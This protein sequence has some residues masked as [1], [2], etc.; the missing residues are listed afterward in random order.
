M[1]I[2]GQQLAGS[3]FRPYEVQ[4]GTTWLLTEFD[5]RFPFQSMKVLQVQLYGSF[6][7][8]YLDDGG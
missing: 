5:G 2:L 7:P 6:L 4:A 8:A 3:S 1:A